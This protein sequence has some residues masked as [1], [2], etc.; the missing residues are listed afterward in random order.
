MQERLW[1][2][3]SASAAS[4]LRQAIWEGEGDFVVEWIE[5]GVRG[6]FVL[7]RHGKLVHREPHIDVAVLENGPDPDAIRTLVRKVK[8]VFGQT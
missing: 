2:S 5:L 1:P 7:F 6:Y 8:A 4:N 3:R